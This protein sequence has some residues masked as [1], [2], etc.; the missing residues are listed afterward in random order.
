MNQ[1][2]E[3]ISQSWLIIQGSLFPWLQEELGSLTEKQGRVGPSQAIDSV[4]LKLINTLSFTLKGMF[5]W[6]EWAL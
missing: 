5:L 4:E 2:R 3:G 1:L 6:V